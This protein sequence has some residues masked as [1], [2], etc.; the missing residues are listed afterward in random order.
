VLNVELNYLHLIVPTFD[1][2]I[3]T[4]TNH[5]LLHRLV[6]RFDNTTLSFYYM[7]MQP[8]RLV[9]LIL[10]GE[11]VLMSYCVGEGM[12]IGSRPVSCSI[13]TDKTFL[14][15]NTCVDKSPN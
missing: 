5:I 9:G 7:I 10:V 6:S 12:T 1:V 11:M 2:K 8:L 3:R 14:S 4:P 15:V 13:G